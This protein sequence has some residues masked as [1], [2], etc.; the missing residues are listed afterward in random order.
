MV[1]TNLSI[2]YTYGL[3][4]NINRY[5]LFLLLLHYINNSLEII[6][7]R[8]FK[9]IDV[10]FYWVFENREDMCNECHIASEYV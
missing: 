1:F 10:V 5:S 8:H 3:E 6:N 2:V 7:M 4:L 9:A